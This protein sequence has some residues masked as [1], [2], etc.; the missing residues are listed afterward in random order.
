[1]ELHGQDGALLVRDRAAK[2]W[3]DLR[4]AGVLGV[5]KA[6]ALDPLQRWID[7]AD[8]LHFGDFGGLWS[9]PFWFVG[10]LALSGLCL[11]G[12][13][14]SVQ[15][16]TQLRPGAGP[17]R[18]VLAA[19]ALTT[20]VLALAAWTGAQEIYAYGPIVAG[21]RR[22]PEVPLGAGLFLAAWLASTLAALTAWMLKAR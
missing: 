11:S 12:A 9:K 21:V 4:S 17:R 1:V 16:R 6:D 20:L 13:Y 5:Q 18:A 14:L 19:Y 15:R 2:V 3:V 7:T 10:G 8:P 22:W